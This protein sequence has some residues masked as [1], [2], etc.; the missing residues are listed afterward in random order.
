M[1]TCRFCAEQV[2][3]GANKCCHCGKFLSGSKKEAPAQTEAIKLPV[4]KKNKEFSQ[5][6]RYVFAA[7]FLQLTVGLLVEIAHS[8][9]KQPIKSPINIIDLAIFYYLSKR[10]ET[11]RIIFIIRLVLGGVFLFATMSVFEGLLVLCLHGAMLLL[12]TGESKKWRVVTAACIST[13][14]ILLVL[15]GIYIK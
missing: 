14:I 1:E 5:D 9:A 4:P 15:T 2:Q 12:V 8:I 10:S 13:P 3:D 11:A 7:I 6:I